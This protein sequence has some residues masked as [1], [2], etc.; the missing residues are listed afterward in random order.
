MP[1]KLILN[2]FI[3]SEQ[4]SVQRKGNRLYPRSISKADINALPLSRYEGK[5]HIVTTAA[6]EKLAVAHLS[7]E[8]ILGFDTESRPS[9]KKGESYPP[10]LVQLA[11]SDAVYLFQLNRTQSIERL[12]PIFT[13][14]SIRKVGIALHDDIKKLRELSDFEPA[15]FEDISDVTKR[16]GI[17]NTGLRSLVGMFLKIRIS[18]GAQV[19]NWARKILNQNQLIYAA[20]DAWMSRALYIHLEQLENSLH[21]QP[22]IV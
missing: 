7:Q 3:L 8:S 4:K 13:D 20:T 2:H 5:V 11:C 1:C 12:I 6:A 18:K 16:L 21:E 17:T 15:S 14:K 22:P 10:S 19:S 9:F